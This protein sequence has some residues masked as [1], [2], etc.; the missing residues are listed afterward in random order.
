MVDIVSKAIEVAARAHA[1][2][3]DKGGKPYILHCLRVM[4]TVTVD[5]PELLAIAVLHDTLE[6]TTLSLD[7][8]RLNFP[9]RVV[10][11]VMALTKVKGESLDAYMKRIKANPDA[12]KV[13]IED[14]AHNMNLERIP[15]PTEKDF[16]RC[17]KYE[18]MYG[19]LIHHQLNQWGYK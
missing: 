8:L 3:V 1:G 9:A 17:E 13:K 19:E 14:L 16:E 10:V 15:N 4:S 5:D 7:W 12:V 18:A 11:G 2:Q 6:D